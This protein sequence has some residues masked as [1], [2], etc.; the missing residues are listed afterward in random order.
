MQI[1][2]KNTFLFS[3]LSFLIYCALDIGTMWDAGTHLRQGKDKLNF[4]L[5]FGQIY[6][7][8]WYDKFFPAI[9]Y[10]ISAFITNIFPKQ[11]EFEVMH[12]VN[13][14]VSLSSVYGITKISKILF[15][16]VVSKITFVLFIFYPIFFGHMSIN[17]KDTIVTACFVWIIYLTLKYLHQSKKY[18]RNIKH[19]FKISFLI[20]LGT[21]VRLGFSAILIPFI[22]FLILEI[23]IF[24]K[25]INKDFYKKLFFLDF[26]K[27]ILI[28]YFIV[29][30]F[31]PQVY[32]NILVMPFTIFLETFSTD[33]GSPASMLNGEIFL[34]NNTPKH[35]ILFNFIYKTPE[36]ILFL[37]LLSLYFF[38]FEN[39]FFK[40]EFKNFNYKIFF[41]VFILVFS[42]ILYILSPYPFYDGMRLFLYLISFFILIPSLCL[43]FIISNLKLFRNKVYLII[44][45]TLA[46]IYLFKFLSLTPYH[47]VYINYLN[48][49]TSENHLKFENDY[50]TTSVKELIKKSEFLR[51]KRSKLTFC[52]SGG[53]KIKKYLKKYNYSKVSL[54]RWDE[55]YDYVL[56]TNRVD[57]SS[58][59][60]INNSKTC[61]QT[62][63]GKNK[64][65]VM[66][67]GLVLSAI[68]I[69]ND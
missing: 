19:L 68:K 10:T 11:Y 53:A 45:S 38:I 61:F 66:R 57:W 44:L 34:T 42:N 41:V 59:D 32:S 1:N 6:E 51:E 3:V 36:Y 35:Y 9:S 21:G 54:V 63:T 33:W 24:K 60:D 17:P 26:L 55:N 12:L 69:K 52:G 13:L 30:I 27:I 22:I 14:T 18:Q 20:A 43:Y 62:F 28:S 37:Y 58:I 40:K 4:L 47:Y 48:G 56:V 46:I 50:L 39:N 15:N 64:S 29:I 8:A 23:F 16:K 67:N 2:K 49:K 5:S 7:E 65:F 31:W 25:F